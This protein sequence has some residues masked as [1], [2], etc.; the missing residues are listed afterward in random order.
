MA[1]TTSVVR[2][3]LFF[4]CSFCRDRPERQEAFP[5]LEP[6]TPS[7]LRQACS[8]WREEHGFPRVCTSRQ[9]QRRLPLEGR[10]QCRWRGI[11]TGDSG[12]H[13][14]RRET[15]AP[16]GRACLRAG[17]S[18]PSVR[19]EPLLHLF[20]RARRARREKH[21]APWPERGHGAPAEICPCLPLRSKRRGY[22]P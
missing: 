21:I 18:L 2:I 19:D 3:F 11:S 22:H 12:G 7:L 15:S 8:L 1:A 10:P 9:L 17:S 5:M 16:E 13:C 20:H 4:I 14:R 6:Q